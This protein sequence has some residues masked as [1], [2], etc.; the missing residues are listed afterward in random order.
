MVRGFVIGLGLCV[1]WLLVLV[2][3]VVSSDFV[4][5]VIVLEEVGG[6]FFIFLCG[7]DRLYMEVWDFDDVGLV[8]VGM[9]YVVRNGML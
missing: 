1:G 3:G 8:M 9:K 4:K 6:L 7:R 2:D 5:S